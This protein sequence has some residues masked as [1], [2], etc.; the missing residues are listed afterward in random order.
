MKGWYLWV[1]MME[2]CMASICAQVQIWKHT[3]G[4]KVMSSPLL[5]YRTNSKILEK[6]LGQ[7][8]VVVWGSFDGY[9]YEF[10]ATSGVLI[11]RKNLF[12]GAISNEIAIFRD[13]MYISTNGGKLI[14]LKAPQ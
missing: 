7:N 8:W 13:T 1:H 12:S 3:G 14:A 4:V 6:C 2:S 5:T 9:V 10:C 11:N